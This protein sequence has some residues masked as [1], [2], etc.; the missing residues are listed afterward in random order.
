MHRSLEIFIERTYGET[1][2]AV[3]GG[4]PRGHRFFVGLVALICVTDSRHF[5]MFDRGWISRLLLILGSPR[6]HTTYLTYC[7]KK[8]MYLVWVNYMF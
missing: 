1:Q 5:C 3:L 4:N 8:Y 7:S 6:L 2:S